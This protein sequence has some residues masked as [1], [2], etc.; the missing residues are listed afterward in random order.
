MSL[1]PTKKT[2]LG[3]AW[4]KGREERQQ[5]ILIHPEYHL[6]VSEGTKTEPNYFEAI[7]EK[8]NRDYK[9]RIQ[10]E[11]EGTGLNTV[12][13]VN[14]A[15][16]YVS[17]SPNG[18][19]H[20][21]VVYDKDDFP[22]EHFNL[23]AE[24]CR[25]K[26]T[27]NTTYHALWSNQCVELWFLLHFSYYQADTPGRLLS[28]T[29]RATDENRSRRIQK[30]SQ[31]YI[32]RAETFY[33]AGGRECQKTCEYQRR[34]NTDRISAGNGSL[35]DHRDAETLLVSNQL[36]IKRKTSSKQMAFFSIQRRMND[37]R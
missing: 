20:V 25:T 34:Q 2:D 30:E 5:S 12:N 7:K 6:I 17:E 1:K 31:G 22:A 36:N 35:P 8:I 19:K 9:D 15:E 18:F 26:T 24:L 16:K 23:A 10:V 28:K 27:E 21:W 32:L 37:W 11:I 14:L 13:L 3:K 29:D 33:G 4:L